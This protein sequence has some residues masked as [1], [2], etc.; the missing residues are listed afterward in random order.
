MKLFSI[1]DSHSIFFEQGGIMASHWTG[2]IHIATIYLLLKEGLNIDNLQ[3]DLAKSDHYTKIGMPPWK[4]NNPTYST[5]NIQPGD[6]VFFWFGFNDIQKNVH[7]YAAEDPETEIYNLISGYLLLLKEYE[8][9][10]KITCIPCSIFPNPAPS[11]NKLVVDSFY[12]ICGDFST[13]GTIEQRNRYTKYANII[14]IDLCKKYNLK[15]FNIYP[16]ITDVQGFLKKEYST[17]YIHLDPHNPALVE[18]MNDAIQLRILRQHY[19]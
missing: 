17:D 5:P 15:F 8:E 7:K 12:G 3:S 18:K 16:E 13:T 11:E 19:I 9:K 10:Y 1:G 14:L 6:A 4:G 2:P